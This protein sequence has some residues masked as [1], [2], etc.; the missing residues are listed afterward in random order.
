MDYSDRGKG[1]YQLTDDGYVGSGIS[2]FGS[3]DPSDDRP[4]FASALPSLQ[5]QST[6]ATIEADTEDIDGTDLRTWRTLLDSDPGNL[7]SEPKMEAQVPIPVPTVFGGEYEL[8]N[9]DDPEGQN[10]GSAEEKVM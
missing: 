6:Q 10:D 9:V 7:S 5:T 4:A 2:G 8:R 3:S 1:L